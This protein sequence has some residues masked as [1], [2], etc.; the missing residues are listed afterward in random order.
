MVFFGF[1]LDEITVAESEAGLLYEDGRLVQ[2]LNAGRYRLWRRPFGP[3]RTVTRVDL[4]RQTVIVP[5]Q[6]M[7][8]ADGIT[9]RLSVAAEYRIADPAIALHTVQNVHGAFYTA[10]QLGLRAEVQARALDA[11]LTER[12]AIG[13]GL[14][15][16]LQPDVDRLGLELGTVGVRDILLSAELRRLLAQEAEAVRAGRAALTAAR[17]EVAAARARANVARTLAETPTLLRLRELETLEKLGEGA[18]NTIIVALP[19]AV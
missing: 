16:R 2:V 8:T 14:R 7:L 6:E 15:V 13:E 4:R 19:A 11:V 5:G 9:L 12:D 17:E 10:L 18:S 3:R 1:E